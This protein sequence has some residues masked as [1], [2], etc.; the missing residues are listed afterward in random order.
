MIVTVNGIKVEIGTP[1]F[2]NQYDVQIQEQLSK[3]ASITKPKKTSLP[4]E[5]KI[6]DVLRNIS[7]LIKMKNA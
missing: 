3:L 1:E 5:G 6:K 7:S 2:G 4:D